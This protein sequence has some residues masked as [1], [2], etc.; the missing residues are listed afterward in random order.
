[1][2]SIIIFVFLVFAGQAFAADKLLQSTDFTYLG[3]FRPPYEDGN[4]KSF[5]YGGG[6]LSY[7]PSHNSLYINDIYGVNLAEIAIPSQS[8]W[9]TATDATTLQT[10][11]ILQNFTDPRDGGSQGIG[12]QTGH[13]QALLSGVLSF[14]TGN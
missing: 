10:T 8:T 13:V 3:A 11:T 14:I 9:K 6:A 4:A 12:T 2:R 1:M 5:G 7:N